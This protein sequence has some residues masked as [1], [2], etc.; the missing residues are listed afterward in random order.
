MFNKK[1]FKGRAQAPGAG[2]DWFGL[3]LA[4]AYCYSTIVTIANE[5]AM[6]GHQR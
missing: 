2:S 4:L 3:G 6:R 1:G 5:W